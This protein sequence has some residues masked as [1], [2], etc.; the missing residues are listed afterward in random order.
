MMSEMMGGMMQSFF[1]HGPSSLCGGGGF[2]PGGGMMQNSWGMGGGGC[3]PGG[4]GGSFTCQTMQFSS[5]VGQDG[6]V[7][8]EQFSSSTVADSSRAVRETKQAYANSATGSQRLSLERQMGDRGRKV[9]QERCSQSGD[10]RRTDI[11]KGISEEQTEEFDDEW[12]QRAAPHLPSHRLQLQLGSGASSSAGP[13]SGARGQREGRAGTGPQPRLRA[14]T[15]STPPEAGGSPS[16]EPG[17]A[18]PAAY[19]PLREGPAAQR[20]PGGPSSLLLPPQSPAAPARS[21]KASGHGARR[22]SPY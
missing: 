19:G 6:R 11:F 18:A 17:R 12:Q 15:C 7:H 10:E 16:V 2:G 21:G 14:L 5:T 13:P 20:R 1:G 9:V 22:P 4:G 8:T 3:F